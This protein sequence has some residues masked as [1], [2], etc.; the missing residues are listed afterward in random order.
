LQRAVRQ[1]RGAI[2]ALG[3]ALAGPEAVVE[4]NPCPPSSSAWAEGGHGQVTING[5]HVGVM[6]VIGPGALTLFDLD[7]PLVGADLSVEAL[8]A[9]FPPK[10]VAQALPAFPGIER[11]LSLIVP[12]Q[13]PWADVAAVVAQTPLEKLDGFRFVGTYRGQQIGPHK[14]SLTLRLRFA[15]PGRTLRHEEVDPQMESLIGRLT[16]ELGAELRA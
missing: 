1:L 14:K 13:L 12:E 15:D 2:E 6:G 16:G 11:D 8:C 3:A 7:I 5:Q 9:G 4:V 10:A